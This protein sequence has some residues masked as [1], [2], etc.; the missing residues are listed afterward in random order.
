[1]T[2][3]VDERPGLKIIRAC[4]E[5]LVADAKPVFLENRLMDS[6]TGCP[7]MCRGFHSIE[8]LQEKN[9]E[10]WSAAVRKMMTYEINHSYIR[11]YVVRRIHIQT[12]RIVC[13]QM[14]VAESVIP[15]GPE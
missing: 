13:D 1:M 10:S 12:I 4:L 11:E 3:K 14:V 15:Y 8:S 5:R 9:K 7:T 6:F 2:E